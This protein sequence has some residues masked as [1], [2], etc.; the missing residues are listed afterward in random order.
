MCP[1]K[2]RSAPHC[3]CSFAVNTLWAG[4]EDNGVR[5]MCWWGFQTN[6]ISQGHTG[7]HD[8]QWRWGSNQ[9]NIGW[10]SYYA[11]CCPYL[12]FYFQ[13][14]ECHSAARG[15]GWTELSQSSFQ[16]AWNTNCTWL[17]WR[18]PL[19][20]YHSSKSKVRLYAI[21]A[22]LLSSAIS[23][24]SIVFFEKVAEPV[25]GLLGL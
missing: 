16:E 1:E 12:S 22:L 3:K 23:T 2:P 4:C 10:A 5:G 20:S 25:I 8:Y 13:G 7:Y 14:K 11:V 18:E 9:D 19:P 6:S 15:R 17:C 24:G 21:Y